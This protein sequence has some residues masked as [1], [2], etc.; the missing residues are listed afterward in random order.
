[1]HSTLHTL[2]QECGL[3]RNVAEISASQIGAARAVSSLCTWYVQHT[4][5]NIRIFYTRSR[6]TSSVIGAAVAPPP[7]A[8]TAAAAAVAAAHKNTHRIR[9]SRF[10]SRQN[11]ETLLC[12]FF[13]LVCT[14]GQQSILVETLN[15]A[16]LKI[17]QAISSFTFFMLFYRHRLSRIF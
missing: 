4:F 14:N 16:S 13:L 7:Q 1:M 12:F 2:H 3:E 10:E 9:A 15:F 17:P 11:Q 6:E 5:A 8:T